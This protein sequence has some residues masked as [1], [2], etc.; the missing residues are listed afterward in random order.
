MHVLLDVSA[1]EPK[2]D[3]YQSSTRCIMVFVAMGDDNKPMA[4]P[5]WIAETGSGKAIADGPV[6]L[7]DTSRA[8]QQ[9]TRAAIDTA[10]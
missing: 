2:A 8:I 5:P 1:T 9:D 7:M 10:Y 4:V 3:N 6:R